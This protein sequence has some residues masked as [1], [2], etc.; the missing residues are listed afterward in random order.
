M[1]IDLHYRSLEYLTGFQE[2]MLRYG[3]IWIHTPWE[4]AEVDS[5]GTGQA[6]EDIARNICFTVYTDLKC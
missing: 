2:P 4:S 6:G 3:D 5:K 1:N